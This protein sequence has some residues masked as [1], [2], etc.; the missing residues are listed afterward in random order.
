ML[1]VCSGEIVRGVVFEQSYICHQTDAPVDALKQI[2]AEERIFGHAAG[3]AALKSS[4]II[5]ALASIVTF[6]KKILVHVGY[7]PRVQI[8]SGI[9]SENPRKQRAVGTGW[10]DLHPRLEHRVPGDYFVAV[11]G[12]FGAVQ[13]VRQGGDEA[14]RAIPGQT[15]IRIQ[16]DNVLDL[17]QDSEIS[18]LHAVGGL[19]APICNQAIE[20]SQLAPFALPAHPAVLRWVPLPFTMEEV[21]RSRS[22]PAIFLVESLDAG[23]ETLKQHAVTRHILLWGVGE[24]GEQGKSQLRIR[25]AQKV[26]FQLV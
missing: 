25:V 2:M 8:E 12:K 18:H 4:H 22:L 7:C 17:W 14:P 16:C 1:P 19:L 5:D 15:R 20:L 26:K 21:E 10:P 13:R 24:I 6:T 3:Q 23:F 9:S 11:R